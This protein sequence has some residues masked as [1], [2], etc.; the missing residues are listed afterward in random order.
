MIEALKQEADS[1]AATF[2]F[3]ISVP[4]I[5]L[6]KDGSAVYRQLFTITLTCATAEVSLTMEES[7]AGLGL[8]LSITSVY[9]YRKK[10]QQK[11]IA[12]RNDE[13][14]K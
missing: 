3:D 8:N 13:A 7:N 10:E 11:K 14:D 9:V 1:T 12:A 6:F 4:A 5:N 2:C